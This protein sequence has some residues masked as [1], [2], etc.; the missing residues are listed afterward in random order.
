MSKDGFQS[1]TNVDISPV[2]RGWKLNKYRLRVAVFSLTS[3]FK[4]NAPSRRDGKP[5]ILVVLDTALMNLE[6]QLVLLT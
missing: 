5:G 1:V 6:S 2:V 3:V 4:R